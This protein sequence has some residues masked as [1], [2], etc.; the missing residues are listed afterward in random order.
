MG[1]IEILSEHLANQI[2]AGEVVERPASVVKELVENALD[3][4]ATE[5]LIELEEGG[6][7][8][9]RVQDNGSGIEAEDIPLAFERHATSKIRRE[10]DLFQIR[11]LG[12]RGEALPSIAS[13]AKVELISAVDDSQLATSISIEGGNRKQ[14]Q[15]VSHPKG[16][17]VIVQDLFYNTPARLKYL[18]TVNTEI[19]HVADYVGR[20]ALA[21]PEVSFT[22]RHEGRELF[23]SIG[24]GKLLHS[25]LALYGKQVASKMTKI[26]GEDADFRLTGYVSKPEVTRSNRSYLT[27]L[28]NGRYVRSLPI[29]QTILQAYGTLLPVGRY[30]VVVLRVEMDPKLC[31]VNVHPAKLE[32]RLSKEKELCQLVKEAI[33]SALGSQRLI[34][35]PPERKEKKSSTQG[36]LIFSSYADSS[37]KAP[38]RTEIKQIAEPSSLYGNRKER[39][40]QK[41]KS[42]KDFPLPFTN[43]NVNKFAEQTTYSPIKKGRQEE[44]LKSA[45]LS[46][47]TK[48]TAAIGLA[49]Q[50]RVQV[51]P[52][53]KPKAEELVTESSKASSEKRLPDLEPLAQVHGTYIVAQ[54]EDG[55][56][57]LD[58]HAAHE[59]VYYERFLQKMMERN[60]EQQP[61]LLPITLECSPSEAQYVHDYLTVLQSW[62]LEIE[63]FGG[64]TFLI[65]AVP[66]WF[67]QGEEESLFYEILNWLQKNGKVETAVLRDASA[68]MMACKA[69][70]KANRHLRKDEMVALLEQMKQCENPFTCPHGRPIYIH[71]SNYELEKMF[72]RVM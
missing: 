30:P 53:T 27:F 67:P 49:E 70:I 20:I 28:L 9:I 36:R 34:P 13:V 39:E 24:D 61:L 35:S 6:I 43:K 63:P 59:R 22:L 19:S 16:T 45:V 60:Q 12:F 55:F 26:E 3:A 38:R 68:K 52:V 7:R 1:K 72:K 64:N 32:V 48:H 40:F 17:E 44:V 15:Q 54:G 25:I 65:R 2:A 41:N 18:K 37:E 47:E 57:L 71:F 23:H 8:K 14:I 31:D 33:Q 5:I 62:G 58:Q 46:K 51:E 11:T 56:Y 66:S 10:R 42:A 50:K 69:A 29:H 4:G 21:H